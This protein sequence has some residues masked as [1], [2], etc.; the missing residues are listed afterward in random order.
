MINGRQLLRKELLL[1]LTSDFYLPMN[2][3]PLRSF[4]RERM[5][6][7]TYLQCQARLR[8]DHLQES[9]IV[10]GVGSLALLWTERHETHQ[11]ISPEHGEKN[12]GTKL[13]KHLLLFCAGEKIPAVGFLTTQTNSTC[14]LRE[15]ANSR[16]M[17]A[18]SQI[19]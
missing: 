9:N 17:R 14:S 12:L 8:G 13:L 16:G 11:L 5:C 4:L 10:S 2:S 3:L 1:H 19:P 15:I 7:L 6:Q 18:E